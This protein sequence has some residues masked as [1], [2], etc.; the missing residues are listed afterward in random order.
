MR[1]FKRRGNVDN[2]NFKFGPVRPCRC[3]K[4]TSTPS[5]F[6]AAAADAWRLRPLAPRTSHPRG[7]AAWQSFMPSDFKSGGGGERR[8]PKP[9]GSTKIVNYR[10]PLV[11]TRFGG[12]SVLAS[13]LVSSLAPPKQQIAS[14]VYCFLWL[15]TRRVCLA[16]FPWSHNRHPGRRWREQSNCCTSRNPIR[17]GLRCA[18]V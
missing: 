14:P 11:V 8:K 4:V 10:A 7:V 13:R 6:K 9:A 17:G 5:F 2:F 1:Q 3:G 15:I 16:S 18:S 12:A